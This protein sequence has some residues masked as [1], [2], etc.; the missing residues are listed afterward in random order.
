MHVVA[1]STPW[2]PVPPVLGSPI[3]E[4]IYETVSGTEDVRMTAISPWSERLREVDVTCPERFRHIDLAACT[5]QLT[6]TM[7]G[8][9]A[10]MSHHE[11]Q[12]FAY[13]S[14]IT[15]LLPD[16]DADVLQ[17]HNAVESL[18]YLI[19]RF[20]RKRTVAWYHNELGF[21]VEGRARDADRFVFVSRNLAERFLESNPTFTERVSVVHNAVDTKQFHPS[22]RQ[23]ASE[24]PT[25]LFVGRTIPEKGIEH[26][27]DA[28]PIV[29]ES[30][31]EA[32]LVIVGSPHYGAV[33]DDPYTNALRE[34]ARRL[35]DAV[36][37]SGYVE[38]NRLPAVYRQADVVAVPSVWAE[39]FGKV[40]VEAMAVGKPV[41]AS[42]RGGIP[43][44]VTDGHDGCLVD[45]PA[46]VP[47]L[48]ETIAGLLAN[49]SHRAAIG[50][51]ARSTAVRRFS[52]TA[53]FRRLR[54]LYGEL[55]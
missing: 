23:V 44:I 10:G 52:H 11:R 12:A 13:L 30:V 48:A 55:A 46:D 35:G 36:R 54:R 51:R 8:R 33:L 28:L 47:V 21:R 31:P 37:F 43:E 5:S 6:A 50:K 29:R 32:R 40:I 15:D 20:P 19:K 9:L 45:D 7:G 25:I 26:L 42:R 2:F 41:V 53:R 16:L 22:G 3:A 14:A 4:T 18:D 39:S 17:V 49:P 1:I 27:I 34:R 24:H 38:R